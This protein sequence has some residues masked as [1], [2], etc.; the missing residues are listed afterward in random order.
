MKRFTLL[1]CFILCIAILLS[2]CEFPF[3]SYLILLN[4]KALNGEEVIEKVVHA[5][6]NED[7]AVLKEL[8]SRNTKATVNTL[9]SDI[10][11][12]I[13]TFEGDIVTYYHRGGPHESHESEYGKAK[14]EIEY[15]Y[16]IETETHKYYVAT[17]CC[18]IDTFDRSN[19]GLTA[20]NYT[21]DQFFDNSYVFWGGGIWEPGIR[22][23]T[24]GRGDGLREP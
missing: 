1:A 4:E 16:I 7:P 5:I 11:Q 24:R 15:S 18:L 19:V 13:Q 8:F 17:L 14:Y 9:D 21:T 23:D 10:E 12:F 6:T 20:I 2:S 3:S 22:F